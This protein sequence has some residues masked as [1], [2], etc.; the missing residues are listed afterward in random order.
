ML[1]ATISDVQSRIPTQL[2]EIG[3]E[4]Q[5]AE[6]DVRAWLE[7]LSRW[8][9]SGLRWKYEVPITEED[10]LAVLAPIVADLAAAR[11]WSV[12]AGSSEEYGKIGDR[13]ERFAKDMLAW[14]RN[15]GRMLIVLPSTTLAED[16]E[17]AVARPAG[18]FTD[19]CGSG[20]QRRLFRIGM[21][22]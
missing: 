18:T 17:A 2:C 13:L 3:P 6:S 10:D 9:D 7:Q 14:N 4:S 22:F 15:T 1:Y 20:N 12:L 11:V 19:P 21:K 16:G 5:P 8:V